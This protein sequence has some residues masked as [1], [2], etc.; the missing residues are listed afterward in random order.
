M[1]R[2]AVKAMAV[3]IACAPLLGVGLAGPATAGPGEYCTLQPRPP[4]CKPG[5]TSSYPPWNTTVPQAPGPKIPKPPSI[6]VPGLPS[7]GIPQQPSRGGDLQQQN[8]S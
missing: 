3:T 7:I 6:G 4:W 8:D 5:G 2:S 1:R